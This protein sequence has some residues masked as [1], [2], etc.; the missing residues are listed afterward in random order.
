[1]VI[2]GTQ[3][4]EQA[5]PGLNEPADVVGSDVEVI[6]DHGSEDEGIGIALRSRMSSS[7]KSPITLEEW[8][9]KLGESLKDRKTFTDLGAFMLGGSVC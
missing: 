2:P 3:G 4:E 7:G 5:A 6:G 9:K 8:Q 1:M